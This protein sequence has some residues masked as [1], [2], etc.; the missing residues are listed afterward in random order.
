MKNLET[1][2]NEFISPYWCHDQTQ[3][4]REFIQEKMQEKVEENPTI[5][6][7]S[8]DL[9]IIKSGEDFQFHFNFK[10]LDSI[11][12]DFELNYGRYRVSN[13]TVEKIIDYIYD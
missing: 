5:Q 11:P 8:N 6:K 2:Y 12:E 10:P 1:K 7:Y 3:Y 13:N 9:E 4:T